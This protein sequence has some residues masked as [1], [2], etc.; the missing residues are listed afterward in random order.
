MSNV[1]DAL[2]RVHERVCEAVYPR[3]APSARPAL[4]AAALNNR[5]VSLVDLGALEKALE[6]L[7]QALAIERRHPQAAYNRLVLSVRT[8]RVHTELLTDALHECSLDADE[9]RRIVEWFGD[10]HEQ[11]P[12][13]RFQRLDPK[14]V[15]NLVGLWRTEIGQTP[16]MLLVRPSRMHRNEAADRA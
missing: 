7:D 3:V 13:P 12:D 11:R 15:V 8:G 10:V 2:I 16:P 9:I 14:A 6:L 1:C 5:A 4:D